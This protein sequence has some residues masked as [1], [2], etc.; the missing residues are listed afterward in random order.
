MHAIV[1]PEMEEVVILELSSS[2]EQ[3]IRSFSEEDIQYPV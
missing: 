3:N 1:S 2:E